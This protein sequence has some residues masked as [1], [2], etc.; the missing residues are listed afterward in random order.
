M[1]DLVTILK[2]P[3]TD[4]FA[5]T[6]EPTQR[7]ELLKLMDTLYQPTTH[8][9]VQT[10]ARSLGVVPT[11]DAPQSFIDTLVPSGSQTFSGTAINKD[12][13]AQTEYRELVQ[14]SEGPRWTIAM[15]KELGR[16]HA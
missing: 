16:A 1:E 9:S 12:T 5:G 10:Q 15:C 3:P 2:H 4:T 7:G 11:K 14:S 8:N 6:L 13:G